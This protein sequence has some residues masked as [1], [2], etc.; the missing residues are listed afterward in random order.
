MQKV[1]FQIFI[2][3][4]RFSAQESHIDVEKIILL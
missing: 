2:V 4:E 1:C 3:V